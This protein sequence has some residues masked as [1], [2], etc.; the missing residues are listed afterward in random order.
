[1]SSEQ[2]LKAPKHFSTCKSLCSFNVTF[3]NQAVQHFIVLYS[4]HVKIILVG[5]QTSER[6]NKIDRYI[7]PRFIDEKTEALGGEET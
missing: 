6:G 3:Q 5:L 1:M 2:T 4:S 7:Y